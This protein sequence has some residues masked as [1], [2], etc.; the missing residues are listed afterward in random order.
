MDRL[1]RV[2]PSFCPDKAD[3]PPRVHTDTVLPTTVASQ[4]RQAI[5]R[6]D[7]EVFDILRS[8]YQLEPPQGRPLH[9]PVDTLDVLLMPDAF[10]VLAPER[11]DQTTSA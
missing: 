7:V 4:S 6:W 2:R 3:A 10:G 11:S 8:M 5:P 1:D 9:G